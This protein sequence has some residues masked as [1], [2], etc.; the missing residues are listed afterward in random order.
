MCFLPQSQTLFLPLYVCLF[1]FTQTASLSGVQHHP[2]LSSSPLLP[3]SPHT[4]QVIQTC[5]VSPLLS[6]RSTLLMHHLT[7]YEPM[8]KGGDFKIRLKKTEREGRWRKRLLPCEWSRTGTRW[9]SQQQNTTSSETSIQIRPVILIHQ[10]GCLLLLQ[11]N[12][13]LFIS[14]PDSHCQKCALT[15]EKHKHVSWFRICF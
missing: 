11:N 6:F 9:V 13:L 8:G 10:T 7:G 3:V 4:N 14:I 1:F 5:R 2:L 12:I 15:G